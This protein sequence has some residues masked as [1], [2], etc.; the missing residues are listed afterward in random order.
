MRWGVDPNKIIT[1]PIGVDTKHF[2]PISELKKQQLRSNLNIPQSAFVI[3]SFQK[4]GQGWGEGLEPKL[5][6]GP[7]IFCDVIERAHEQYDNIFVLLTGPSRGYVKRRLEAKKIP[8][9]HMFLK[10]YLDI[11]KYYQVL[12]MYLV[13][14]RAE[15][16]PKAIMES[17]ATGIPL[18]ST[19]VGMGVDILEHNSNALTSEIDDVDSL[20]HNVR[21]IISDPLLASNITNKGLQ[22]S[23]Q[24]DWSII[25]QQYYDKIY[26]QYM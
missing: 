4:D 3:G 17:M 9:K 2:V 23:R 1:I 19:K 26:K 22:T 5:I 10:D 20:V 12:D 13:A 16:G 7:D 8:Y 21:K 15:G 25:A 11:N 18:V 24:L 14:S 6:K